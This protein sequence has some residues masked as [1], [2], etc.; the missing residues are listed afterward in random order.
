MQ[1]TKPHIEVRN[2]EIYYGNVPAVRGV[3]F[4]DAR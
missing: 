2:L 1:D 4:S 3:S